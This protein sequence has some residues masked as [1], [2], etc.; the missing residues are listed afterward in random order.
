V[1]VLV[2]GGAGFLGSTL[3]DRLLAG[4]HRVEVIDNLSTGS[5]ANLG[6]ARRLGGRE[7]S[8]HQLD[9]RSPDAADVIARHRPEVIW[10]LAGHSPT[11]ASVGVAALD[12]DVNVVGTLKIAAAAHGAGCRKLVVASSATAVYGDAE[13]LP[14]RESDARR[15]RSPHGVGKHAVDS[16]L[17][18]LRELE[19]FEYTSLVVG[20]VYGPRQTSGVV[21]AWARWVR[22]G[23]PCRVWGDGA[24][25]RDFVFVDDVVDALVRAAQHG[26]GMVLNIGTGV[27]TS[28][29]ALYGL[30]VEAAVSAGAG[31]G[32]AGAELVQV[33]A[34]PGDTR[35]ISLDPTRAGLHLDWRAWT[36]LFDGLV[37]VMAATL[38]PTITGAAATSATTAGPPDLPP[39]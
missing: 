19:G 9:V 10:H 33:A 35:R 17:A 8:F 18:V 13:R 11:E 23:Q 20:T 14:V 15:P 7:F 1:E 22:A 16:Y 4:G 34:R 2:T 6:E 32:G 28:L 25:T 36:S 5:L 37:A 27:E 21:A 3:V 26:N 31:S 24:Q 30:L 39:G 29:R 12:A 38:A